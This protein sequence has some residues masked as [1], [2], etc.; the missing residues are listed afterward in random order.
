MIGI[1]YPN[2]DT[3]SSIK[4]VDLCI[5]PFLLSTTIL[6]ANMS[7]YNLLPDTILSKIKIG[8]TQG[9]TLALEEARQPTYPPNPSKMG[10]F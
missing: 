1:D 3:Y 5:L 4:I 6:V 9:P 7:R 10:L 8:L 2:N